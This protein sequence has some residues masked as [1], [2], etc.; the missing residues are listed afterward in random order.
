MKKIV[1]EFQDDLIKIEKENINM[2]MLEVL[3]M[4]QD[5]LDS[6][7]TEYNRTTAINPKNLIIGGGKTTH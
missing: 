3:S 1:I 2:G 4:L 5:V 7:I 6:A